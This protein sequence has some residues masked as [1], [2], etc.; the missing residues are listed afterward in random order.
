MNS[1][2]QSYTSG[3]MSDDGSRLESP[4]DFLTR[5]PDP[6]RGKENENVYDFIKNV[7]RVFYYKHLSASSQVYVLKRL[8]K[9]DAEYTVCESKSLAENFEYLK[10]M[11]GNPRA[12][13]RKE[14]E[15]FFKM[16]Q[17]ECWNWTSSFSPQRKLMLVKV[18]G[19]LKRAVYLDKEFDSLEGVIFSDTTV[20]SIIG[21]LPQNIYWEIIKK[22]RKTKERENRDFLTSVEILTII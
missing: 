3:S 21:I 8:V 12:I 2:N 9:D 5:Y 17:D 19:F 16:C 7:E 13:W 18:C 20:K 1:D 15:K 11:F 14:K 22:I 10:K 4:D 6:F